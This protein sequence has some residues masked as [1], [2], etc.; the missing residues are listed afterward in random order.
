MGLGVRRVRAADARVRGPAEEPVRRVV[1]VMT[2]T[3]NAAGSS[4]SGVSWRGS[5]RCVT[6]LRLDTPRDGDHRGVSLVL[7]AFP[8]L[9]ALRRL[10]LFGLVPLLRALPPLSLEPCLLYTS[11][12][13]RD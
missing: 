8:A 10:G 1:T 3:F 4:G 2:T 13:P 6:R 11:P 9:S 12:S 5:F 7:L